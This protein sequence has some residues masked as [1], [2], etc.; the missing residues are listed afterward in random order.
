[1]K[2]WGRWLISLQHHLLWYWGDFAPSLSAAG[3]LG[4]HPQ[5]CMLKVPWNLR[6]QVDQTAKIQTPLSS[7][8]HLYKVMPF[9]HWLQHLV[10]LLQEPDQPHR[11]RM[12][13]VRIGFLDR[14]GCG[15]RSSR[16]AWNCIPPAELQRLRQLMSAAGVDLATL[17]SLHSDHGWMRLQC[18]ALSTLL[19]YDC[20]CFYE[21]H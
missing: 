5:C 9:K 16:D 18:F 13:I 10:G 15:P 11:L 3:Y 6:S 4:L 20:V 8:I 21:V 12:D 17:A 19:W 1:M 2:G 7:F 14:S